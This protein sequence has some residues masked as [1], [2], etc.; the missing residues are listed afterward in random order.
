MIRRLGADRSGATAVEFA[1]VSPALILCLIGVFNL[2]LA[3]YS[4]AAVRNAVQRASRALIAN[5]STPAATLRASAVAMLVNVPAQNLTITVTQE[6]VG[7]AIV[8]RVSW[9]YSY[10]VAIPFAPER[11][12]SFDSSLLAPLP[13]S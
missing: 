8:K 12:F 4:G 6:T 3:L 2:G 9:T 11:T 7:Q 13:P 1:L 10:P 5:P